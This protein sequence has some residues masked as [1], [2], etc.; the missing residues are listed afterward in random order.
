MQL[1][2]PDKGVFL[3]SK[4]LKL[5]PRIRRVCPEIYQEALL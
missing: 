5:V 2:L 4:F 1:P 3:P